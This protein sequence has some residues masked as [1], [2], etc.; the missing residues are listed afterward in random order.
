[1]RRFSVA[2]ITAFRLGR[3]M[4]VAGAL[5]WL[6][7]CGSG[8]S[9]RAPGGAGGTGGAPRGTFAPIDAAAADQPHDAAPVFSCAAADD[10]GTACIQF[11][12]DYLDPAGACAAHQGGPVTNG[13]CASDGS[14]GGCHVAAGT[15]G[16]TIWTYGR[17]TAGALIVRCQQLGDSY[18]SP[19]HDVTVDAS[20]HATGPGPDRL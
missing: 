9:A 7:G 14:A 11:D 2:T 1:M 4:A 19:G 6:G 8:A 3:S 5:A 17:Q 13:P 20:A 12:P 15:S 16:Y 10:G 18:V